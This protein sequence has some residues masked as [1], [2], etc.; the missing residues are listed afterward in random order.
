MPGV[1]AFLISSLGINPKPVVELTTHRSRWR[2]VL[3]LR[4]DTLFPAG[5]ILVGLLLLR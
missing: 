2:P 5:A 1:V 4:A 3:M